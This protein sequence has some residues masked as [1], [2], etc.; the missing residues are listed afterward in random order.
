VRRAVL[1]ALAVLAAGCGEAPDRDAANAERRESRFAGAELTV[2]KRAPDFA[3]RDQD[4]ALVRLS[5][6][7]GRYVIVTFLYT[8][9][10]DVCPLIATN[11]NT[12]LRSLGPRRGR[13]RVLAVSVDP[14]GDTPAAVRAYAR[15]LRLLPQFRYLIG[16]KSGLTP[17]W[18]AYGVFAVAADHELVDHVASTVLV[19]REG[20]RRVLY[21]AHVKAA[22]VQKDLR[23]LMSGES[24]R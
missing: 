11:L 18:R 19:D 24:A 16:T 8:H 17:V 5:A 15:R 4:G 22:D 23:T 6:Q 12:A 7:R 13:V 14:K 2:A 9:C 3:L 1:L 10:P 21:G 20:R